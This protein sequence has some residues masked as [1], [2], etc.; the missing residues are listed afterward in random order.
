MNYQT[1]RNSQ[2][3]L[4]VR[5][6]PIFMDCQRDELV[7]DRG[8]IEKAV[9]QARQAADDNYFPPLHVRHHG[10]GEDVRPAGFFEIT[11][12]EEITFRGK[13]R[14]A[15]FADLT[16]TASD[17]EWEVL[18]SRLPYRSVEIMRAD[19]PNIDS[20]ALLDHEAPYLELPMLMVTDP[21]PRDEIGQPQAVFAN[22]TIAQRY[23]PEPAKEGDG[24][25]VCFRRGESA[26]ILFDQREETQMA[27]KK[28]TPATP[29]A[30]PE[31]KTPAE[32]VLFADDGG[33]KPKD[34]DGADMAEGESKGMDVKAV[35]KAIESGEISVAD[36]DAIMAAIAAQKGEAEG[37]LEDPTAIV[38]AP[39]PGAAMSKNEEEQSVR[40]ARLQAQHDALEAKVQAREAADK[41]REDVAVAMQRLEGKPM[42]ANLKQR[43][44]AYHAEHGPAAFSAYA[45]ELA[46]LFADYDG[47]PAVS[48][49][50]QAPVNASAAVD[51][52][53][54]DGP[55]ALAE[56]TKFSAQWRQLKDKGYVDMTEERYLELNMKMAR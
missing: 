22:A 26:V 32:P 4:V 14:L 33:D 49:S 5:G 35:C 19:R 13:T 25:V 46:N 10:F 39:I 7:F 11:H 24:L 28:K 41:L 51:K 45:D 23:G 9:S 21:G 30:K 27:A 17:V 40:F 36:M 50:A 8:W 18:E 31:T 42:G 12:S 56:A 52:Y 43:L 20:L 34:D 44:E 47:A 48:G 6:V 38:E 3:H 53:S 54:Q 29:A 15:I 2:G 55:E 37:E 1:E 16:V